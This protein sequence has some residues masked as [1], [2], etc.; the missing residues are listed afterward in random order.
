MRTSQ[1]RGR[2][3]ECCEGVSPVVLRH[4]SRLLTLLAVF[5][6]ARLSPITWA[7]C[8]MVGAVA[9]GMIQ[10][11]NV[12]LNRNELTPRSNLMFGFNFHVSVSLLQD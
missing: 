12:N 10:K 2:Q 1:Q 7:A 8:W 9:D 5:P 6:E 3:E 11:E 4:I